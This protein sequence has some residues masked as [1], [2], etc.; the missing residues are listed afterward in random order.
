MITLQSLK[1]GACG[2]VLAAGVF[3][4]L[5]ANATTVYPA[6]TEDLAHIAD[7]IV[8]GEVQ[9]VHMQAE[10]SSVAIADQ[11]IRTH[12][13]VKVV[14]T[15]K[16]DAKPGDLIDVVEV[17]GIVDGQGFELAGSLGY[18]VGERV[19]LFLQPKRG[20]MSTAYLTLGV[21]LGKYTV[22]TDNQG[23]PI[24]TRLRW[25]LPERGKVFNPAHDVAPERLR[26]G[27]ED[28]AAF[29]AKVKAV[30]AADKAA[31]IDGK[32]LKKYDGMGVGR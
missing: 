4:T 18:K 23:T 9:S 2:L 22:L 19:L 32:W 14:E 30:V 27:T 10:R 11:T 13:A 21:F 12:N 16:G 15:W 26:V 8:V 6:T 29:S 28:F 31:G 25:D 5:G 24:L 3:G 17:G 20:Y 7:L 1:A